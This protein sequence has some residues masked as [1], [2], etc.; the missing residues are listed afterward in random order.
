LQRKEA[1][2]GGRAQCCQVKIA[3]R[4]GGREPVSFLIDTR[5]TGELPDNQLGTMARDVFPLTSQGI[6][7]AL[8]LRWSICAPTAAY[9]HS[10]RE[11]L[12][13]FWERTEGVAQSVSH[14]VAYPHGGG[15]WI[16]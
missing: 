9:E 2:R 4:G 13:L 11:D 14:P 16:L 6:I 5:V 7:D 15:A 10:G 1:G 3:H 12:D 8:D